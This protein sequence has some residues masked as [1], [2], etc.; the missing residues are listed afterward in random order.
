MAK[1][2]R[3]PQP[4]IVAKD[5]HDARLAHGAAEDYLR[6]LGQG[7]Q[8]LFVLAGSRNVDSQDADMIQFIAT[9]LFDCLQG[10]RLNVQMTSDKLDEMAR[11][12]DPAWAAA[13]PP[14]EDAA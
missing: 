5:V 13:H 12:V 2:K 4:G 8:V 11:L 1:P 6:D 3:K 7:V 10:A 9:G 14:K